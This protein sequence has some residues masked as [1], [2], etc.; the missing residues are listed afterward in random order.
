MTQAATLKLNKAPAYLN[1]ET[2]A[3]ATKRHLSYRE[4]NQTE[5][6]DCKRMARLKHPFAEDYK[7]IRAVFDSLA[8]ASNS[9]TRLWF[10]HVE[11]TH[12][13]VEIQLNSPELCVS[14]NPTGKAGKAYSHVYPAM[15]DMWDRYIGYAA[16]VKWDGAGPRL[17]L[18]F[19]VYTGPGDVLNRLLELSAQQ[20][21]SIRRDNSG[22]S[23]C[24]IYYHNVAEFR[25]MKQVFEEA[26][27][28]GK[29]ALPS[30]QEMGTTRVPRIPL[31]MARLVQGNV[32]QVTRRNGQ[33]LVPLLNMD[34]TYAQ[35]VM[36]HSDALFALVHRGFPF[37]EARR[38][39]SPLVTPETLAAMDARI[40]LGDKEPITMASLEAQ[41]SRPQTTIEKAYSKASASHQAQR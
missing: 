8:F 26:F 9:S 20:G 7:E 13:N 19:V 36:A 23:S 4:Y 35:Q 41:L 25:L 34:A 38:W 31:A 1:N 30:A 33:V 14:W 24:Y 39:I 11:G 17:S 29:G 32:K 12:T 27:P 22:G 16:R 15:G 10:L 3:A 18:P 6:D 2:L 28:Q 40:A 21:L 5:R 37:P